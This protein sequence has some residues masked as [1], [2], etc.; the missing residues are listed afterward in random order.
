MYKV[1]HG[2]LPAFHTLFK[3]NSEL[4]KHDTRQKSHYHPPLFRTNLG[5]SSLRYVGALLW[6][7]ILNSNIDPNVSNLIF[8]RNLKT[9]ICNKTLQQKNM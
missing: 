8:S 3:T 5:K 1:H 2:E 6:N 4:H 7:D 9:A